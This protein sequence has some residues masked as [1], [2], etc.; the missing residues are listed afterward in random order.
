AS[1]NNAQVNVGYGA[2]FTDI[3][4]FQDAIAKAQAGGVAGGVTV[5]AVPA[6]V[7]GQ[8]LQALFRPLEQI[9][10][11]AATLSARAEAAVQAGTS[12]TPGEMVRMSVK[13]QEFMFSCQLTSN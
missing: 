8:A 3:A 7:P 13:V 10:A 2:S 1:L 5:Y 6:P 4:A 12:M 9:N 11:Q